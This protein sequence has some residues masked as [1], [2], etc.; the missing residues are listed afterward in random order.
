M[1][2]G[3]YVLM[4]ATTDVFDLRIQWVGVE[5]LTKLVRKWIDEPSTY[6]AEEMRS[7]LD[8]WREVLF[9]HLDQ[10]VGSFDF[11]VF[12]RRERVLIL[13]PDFAVEIPDGLTFIRIRYHN[14]GEGPIRRKPEKVLDLGGG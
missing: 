11:A 4:K 2:L 7:C 9:S 13:S 14:A 3:C 8:S 5:G 6:N 10:E 1:S 12:V